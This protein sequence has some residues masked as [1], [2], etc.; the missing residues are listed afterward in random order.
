MR[1]E[2]L[3]YPE[4]MSIGSH[5]SLSIL[6]LLPP[7]ESQRRAWAPLAKSRFSVVFATNSTVKRPYVVLSAAMIRFQSVV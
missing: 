2:L 7:F 5:I 3:R 6:R 1:E 4:N